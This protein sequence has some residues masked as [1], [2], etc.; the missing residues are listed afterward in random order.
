MAPVY[1]IGQLLLWLSSQLSCLSTIRGK[2]ELKLP[3][4]SGWRKKRQQLKHWSEE[5]V[6]TGDAG[7]KEVAART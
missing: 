3:S 2:I 1:G 5:A 7:L 4:M 6:H